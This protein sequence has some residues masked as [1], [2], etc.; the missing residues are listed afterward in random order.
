MRACVGVRARVPARMSAFF[1]LVQFVPSRN[2][3]LPEVYIS[4][5]L[6][7][8]LSITP[9]SLLGNEVA[10]NAQSLYGLAGTFAGFSL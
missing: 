7:S 5:R 1:S 2:L 10:K 8:E 3:R 4:R 9:T 6:G